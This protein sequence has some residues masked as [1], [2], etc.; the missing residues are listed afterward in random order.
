MKADDYRRILRNSWQ[1]ILVSTLLGGLLGFGIASIQPK[2][3]T[4][5]SQSFVA[6]WEPWME[7]RDYS[8]VRPSRLSV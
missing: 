3:F 4:A 8:C 6:I 2:V 7:S 5:D 1:W